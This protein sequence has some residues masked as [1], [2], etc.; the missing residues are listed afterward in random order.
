MG[1]LRGARNGKNVGH[2]KAGRKVY[3]S[4]A[5]MLP[6]WEVVLAAAL[7]AAGLPQSVLDSY[8]TRWGPC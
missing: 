8:S 2:L 3:A 4:G 1:P 7:A 5:P 6:G